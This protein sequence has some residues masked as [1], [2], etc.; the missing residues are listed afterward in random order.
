MDYRKRNVLTRASI[1]PCD[2][3]RRPQTIKV[4]LHFIIK[5]HKERQYVYHLV[6]MSKLVNKDPNSEL[7][8][9]KL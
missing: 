7:E 2:Y 4:Q 5:S 8:F 9:S 1:S 6:E 3:S